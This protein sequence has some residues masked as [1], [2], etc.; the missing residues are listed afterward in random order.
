MPFL[1]FIICLYPTRYHLYYFNVK[2]R[3]SF[4]ECYTYFSICMDYNIAI[5]NT[6]LHEN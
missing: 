5:N 2:L 6:G 1:F 4:K 3:V